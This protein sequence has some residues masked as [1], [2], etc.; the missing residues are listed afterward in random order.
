[1][2]WKFNPYIIDIVPAASGSGSGL[3]IPPEIIRLTE[4]DIE[5]KFVILSITPKFPKTVR[6]VCEG[7]LEQINGVD[8]VVV[9]NILTWDAL[10]LD[11]FLDST[12]ALIIHY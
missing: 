3:G 6:L 5:N 7:G 11:N 1:M 4:L 8:F 12:D 10:G 9:E 2:F